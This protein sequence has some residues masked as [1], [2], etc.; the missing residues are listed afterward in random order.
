MEIVQDY[1]IA[2]EK[3]E[4]QKSAVPFSRASAYPILLTKLVAPDIMVS[5]LIMHKIFLIKEIE[6]WEV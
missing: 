3:I 6:P 2:A 5:A 1:N 4:T